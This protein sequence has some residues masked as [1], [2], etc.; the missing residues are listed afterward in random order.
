VEDLRCLDVIVHNPVL[1][2]SQLYPRKRNFVV[3]GDGRTDLV[4]GAVKEVQRGRRASVVWNI[5]DGIHVGRDEIVVRLF[6]QIHEA[7]F[8]ADV[9]ELCAPDQDED[10][11]GGEE[12]DGEEAQRRKNKAAPTQVHPGADLSSRGVVYIC[13]ASPLL[14]VFATLVMIDRLMFSRAS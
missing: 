11:E 1:L 9:G 2:S 5:D 7:Q 10:E 4:L 14:P 6:W 3:A 13:G 8:A 12:A